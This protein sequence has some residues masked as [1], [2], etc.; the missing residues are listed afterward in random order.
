MAV[1]TRTLPAIGFNY[2]SLDILGDLVGSRS[3]AEMTSLWM[4]RSQ[5][6]TQ[7]LD[8]SS[9]SSVYNVASSLSELL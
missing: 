5:V 8:G 3:T 9:I 2:E 6:Y 4:A 7:S 1:L